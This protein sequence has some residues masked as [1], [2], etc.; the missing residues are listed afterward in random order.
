[1]RKVKVIKILKKEI[2]G[3][4]MPKVQDVDY[5]TQRPLI[6]NYWAGY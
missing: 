4:E 2:R 1:M 5:R 3:K 6:K